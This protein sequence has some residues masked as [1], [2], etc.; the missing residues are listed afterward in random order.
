MKAE[1]KPRIELENRTKLQDVI[2][3]RTPLVL[4]VEPTNLC[5]LGCRFC[6]VG[7]QALIKQSGIRQGMMAIDLFKKVIDDLGGFQDQ[8]KAMHLYGNGEPLLNR[9]FPDMVRYAKQSGRVRFIDTTTNGLLLKPEKIDALVESGIDKINVSVNGLTAKQYDEVTQTPIDFVKFQKNLRYLF[10]NRGSCKV[11]IKS[12]SELYDDE[13]KERFFDMF[14]SLADYI[15][16]ENLTDPWPHYSTEEKMGTK[17]SRSAF[18]DTVEQKDVCCLIFYTL[19]VNF[20]GTV[21]LCCVDWNNDLV[22]GDTNISSLK[23]IWGSDIL[24]GHQMRHLKGR[25]FEN[26]ICRVCNQISQCVTDNVDPYR[27]ELAARLQAS[28]NGRVCSK[29]NGGI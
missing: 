8:I 25:R 18:F 20:D 17:S 22:V 16:L 29:F 2:P 13:G 7:D 21:S 11:Y 5:N 24:F 9:H 28:R 4:H 10:D 23:D 26:H 27:H 6:P 3:L 12:I 15:F 1:I 14:S 19:V